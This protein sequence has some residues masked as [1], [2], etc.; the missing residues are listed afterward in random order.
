MNASYEILLLIMLDIT[1]TIILII[2][3]KTIFRPK[4]MMNK[5]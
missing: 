5:I 3:F 2:G 4:E 1:I